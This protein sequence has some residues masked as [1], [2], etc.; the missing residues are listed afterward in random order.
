MLRASGVPYDVRRADPYGIY[1]RFDFNVAVRYNGDVYD[2]YLVRMD[3]MRESIKIL[4]QAIRDM[5]GGE[6]QTGKPQYQARVPAGEAY[7]RAENPKG[8]LGYYVLSN[9]KPNPYRYHIRAPSFINLTPLGEMCKGA[10]VADAVVIL[11]SID[12]VLGETDR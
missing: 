4:Q 7:G 1:D 2:R 6:I 11:G 5:P 3:E 8:E 9:G 10:K 12:I